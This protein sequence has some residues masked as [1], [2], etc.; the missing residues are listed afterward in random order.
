MGIITCD[1]LLDICGLNIYNRNAFRLLDADVDTKG[2]RIKRNEVELKA[3]LEV[4]ELAEE[5]CSIFRPNPL[6]TH[7][8]LSE[9]ARVLSDVQQRFVH[10][11][12]WFWPLEWGKSVSD[13]AL[14]LIKSHKVNEAKKLW[15]Q[16]AKNGDE[17]SLVAKHNLAVLGHWLA[18][19][20]ERRMLAS[21]GNIEFTQEKRKELNAYWNFAFKNWESLCADKPFWSVQTDRISALNDPRL[22][23][24]FLH[25]FRQSLPIAF[26]NINADLAVAYCDRAMYI[27]AK[28]HVQIMKA[29]N[30]GYDDVDT[31]LRRVTEPLHNRID[32]AVDTATSQLH[33]NKT[34]GKERCIELFNT[35]RQ[36]LNVMR[37]LLGKESQEFTETCERVANSMLQC[38]VAYG[39]E[40]KDWKNLLSLLELT[41]KVARKTET[42]A[43]IEQS[44]LLVRQNNICWFCEKRPK[45]EQHSITIHLKKT[46]KWQDIKRDPEKYRPVISQIVQQLAQGFLSNIGHMNISGMHLLTRVADATKRGDYREVVSA[47]DVYMNDSAEIMSQQA[48]QIIPRCRTCASIHSAGEGA[49]EPIDTIQTKLEIANDEIESMTDTLRSLKEKIASFSQDPEDTGF[50]IK[51]IKSSKLESLHRQEEK[52]KLRYQAAQRERA[53]LQSQLKQRKSFG[54]VKEFSDYELWPPIVE[55]KKDGF[56]IT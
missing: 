56:N 23:T 27:R 26:D 40:T 31:S 45:N 35:V 39:T 8:E 15:T 9:A 53:R 10:E 13:K 30:A 49:L 18:L 11:F 21:K 29:T 28:D 54:N 34:K 6:P 20:H 22:T 44:I 47:I 46:I 14:N 5:Y 7:E 38:Q 41:R 32:R 52:I 37:I 24:G 19:D 42:L 48:T 51:R 43:L 3:A 12:F 4:G 16:I 1:I 25:S 2:R 36:I 50:L 33:N 55:A 17:A